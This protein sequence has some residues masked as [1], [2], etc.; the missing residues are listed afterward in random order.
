MFGSRS[1]AVVASFCFTLLAPAQPRGADVVFGEGC[2]LGPPD[3]RLQ[4][5]Y[6]MAKGSRSIRARNRSSLKR[7]SSARVCSSK[8]SPGAESK[9]FN[10][11]Q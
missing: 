2:F 8:R 5:Y 11:A 3:A 9:S 4:E 6:C 10:T 7:I 1:I